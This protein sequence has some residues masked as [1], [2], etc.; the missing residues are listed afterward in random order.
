MRII[1]TGKLLTGIPEMLA[2][3]STVRG[4]LRSALIDL[5]LA[6]FKICT[7]GASDSQKESRVAH[8]NQ[9]RIQWLMSGE[10][11]RYMYKVRTRA[12]F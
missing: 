4:H 5:V 12:L 9:K 3:A 1:L 2:R 11:P 7:T 8:K 10:I 6:F